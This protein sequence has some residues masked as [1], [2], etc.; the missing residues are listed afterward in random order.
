MDAP[1]IASNRVSCVR[2]DGSYLEDQD[3]WWLA[4]ITRDVYMYQRPAVH[5]RDFAV[6]ARLDAPAADGYDMTPAKAEGL[7][8]VDLE[9]THRPSVVSLAEDLGADD[10]TVVSVSAELHERDASIPAAELAM[11]PLVA[12]T[13]KTTLRRVGGKTGANLRLALKVPAGLARP[14]SAESPSLYTLFLTLRGPDGTI[15]EV[16]SQRVGLRSVEVR[17]GRLLVNGVSVTLRGVNRHEHDPDGGH[18]VSEECMR[19]DIALMK[20]LNFNCVRCSHYPND[21]RWYELCDE[22]GLYVIDE[23]N[24]ESHGCGFKPESTLANQPRFHAAH[25]DRVR[26]VCE[27]DK[28]FPSV[29]LWSLGNEAGNGPAFHA[30]Y[31]W[32]KKRDPTRPVQYENARVEPGW[33]TENVETIDHDTDLY[34]PM[35]PSPDKLERYA[36]GAELDPTALPLIMCEYA[37]AMGN[38]CGG[39]AQY[40]DVINKYGVLQGGCIWDWVDQGLRMPA[41]SGDTRA[42]QPPRRPHFGY[43]GDFGPAGTPSDETFCI[44]GL[45]QPDR[46]PNPH[47]FEAKYCQQPVHVEAD[48]S[49]GGVGGTSAHLL[50]HNRH[51]FT[52]LAES[53][54]VCEWLLLADG[55]P[56][57]GGRLSHEACAP[58]ATIPISLNHSSDEQCM[59]VLPRTE[60]ILEVRFRRTSDGHE[61]AWAQ[62]GVVDAANAAPPPAAPGG[63]AAPCPLVVDESDDRVLRV[64]SD[65]LEVHFLK[66]TGLPCSLRLHG[67]EL[68]HSPLE[69]TLW[70]PLNDNELGS[71]AHT[72]VRRF[73]DAGR[74]SRGGYHRL[75]RP[76]H[77]EVLDG[78]ARVRVTAEASL[79]ADGEVGLYT[80]CTARADGAIE[81]SARVFGGAA[82]AGDDD[83]NGGVGFCAEST[84]CLRS[85]DS[86]THLDVEDQNVRA[87]W[88]DAGGWQQLTLR[89]ADEDAGD[90]PGSTNGARSGAAGR[91]LA[92]GDEV[93]LTAHT[94]HYL[95]VRDGAIVAVGRRQG[96]FGAQPPTPSQRWVIEPAEGSACIA[97]QRVIAGAPIALRSAVTDV[98]DGLRS[99]ATS[100]RVPLYAAPADEKGDALLVGVSR[101]A[102]WAMQAGERSAPL[103][104]GFETAVVR[105][106]ANR[107]RWHGL[108]PHESYPDRMAGA[109]VGRYDEPVSAQTFRYCRPQENGNKMNTRWMALSD[110]AGTS[111]L[112][113]VAGRGRPL[114]MQCHHFALEDFDVKPDSMIPNV[115]H[116]GILEERQLTTLCIDGAHAGVGGIDSWGSQPLMQHRLSLETPVEWAF[117]LRP[118]DS[119]G[120]HIGQSVAVA[121]LARQEMASM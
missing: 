6:R 65:T 52:P 109:R 29:I 54:F 58:H 77:V 94:G 19:R 23:A 87:R 111:G 84:V 34:V 50:V 103:R 9:L 74:A 68:L 115:R 96:E 33:S 71:R 108:G 117:L 20:D 119:H 39:L 30:A 112:L 106:R 42:P 17:C 2:C 101:A 91:Q 24:I 15:L 14:W 18:V 57:R 90:V 53:T 62:F 107:V 70:R 12:Q 72:R 32:L 44:N 83:T 88:D 114:P 56:V 79:A 51:D 46:L 41:K 4:G 38:S 45:V 110:A 102:G 113:V 64:Y 120:V 89:F 116:G 40:W 43:G 27:R 31:A 80:V 59:Q 118:F 61:V 28:N 66:A 67:E 76:L 82:A 36:R 105:E 1:R 55:E 60:R 47:A 85:V 86:N 104:V 69:P 81:V 26:R 8:E 7:V 100:G 93:S 78:G 3:M 121:E 98:T 49:R 92:Y 63:L 16:L 48:A 11:P 21:E 73:R 22:M 75:V 10:G 35:Y 13:A 37:H 25:L 99:A 5:V 97:G 95:G